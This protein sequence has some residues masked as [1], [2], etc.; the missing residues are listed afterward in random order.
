MRD[1]GNRGEIQ[2]KLA[3]RVGVFKWRPISDGL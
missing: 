1:R 2:H 3:Q